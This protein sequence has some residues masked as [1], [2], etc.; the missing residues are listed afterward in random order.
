MRESALFLIVVSIVSA[1]VL[2]QSPARPP[3]SDHL[4]LAIWPGAAPGSPGTLPPER[5]RTTAK[6][7]LVAGETVLRLGTLIGVEDLR[8]FISGKGF[9]EHLDAE[10]SL[11]GD[12]QLLGQYA[13]AEPVHHRGQIDE[14]ARH[15]AVR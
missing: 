3:S 8:F 5:D 11:H 10:R 6:D 7:D 1:R 14:A 2:G 13:A 15:R 4:T 9:V 12:R